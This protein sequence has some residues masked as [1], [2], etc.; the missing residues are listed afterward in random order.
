MGA[1]GD[2]LE[3]PSPEPDEINQLRCGKSIPQPRT[4]ALGSRGGESCRQPWM[5]PVVEGGSFPPMTPLLSRL[6]LGLQRSFPFSPGLPRAAGMGP[7]G[8]GSQGS[9]STLSQLGH[10]AGLVAGMVFPPFFH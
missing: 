7:A 6:L 9:L 8:A 10:G 2:G 1:V 3:E 4:A 5:A